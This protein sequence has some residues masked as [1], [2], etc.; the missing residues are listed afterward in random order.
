[1][2]VYVLVKVKSQVKLSSNMIFEITVCFLTILHI[3]VLFVYNPFVKRQFLFLNKLSIILIIIYLVLN[4][5]FFVY[6]IDK[7]NFALIL[8]ALSIS[9]FKNLHVGNRGNVSN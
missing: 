3:F 9:F 8:V 1:M 5:P 2:L 4:F 7:V 6:K